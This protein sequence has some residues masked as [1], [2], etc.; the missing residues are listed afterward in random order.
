[1]EKEQEK[2][3]QSVGDSF[4]NEYIKTDCNK[5]PEKKEFKGGKDKKKEK[6]CN[7]SF[8]F[9][10][11]YTIL[12]IIEV[13]VFLLTYAIP[14]GNFAKMEYSTKNKVF[15]I[16]YPLDDIEIYENATQDT[17]DKY[18]IKIPLEN[19]VNN[20]IKKPISI[21]DTYQK[22]DNETTSFFFII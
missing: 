10:T 21:P 5:S 14:K 22:I 2:M 12:I 15:I 19:F 6:Y 16:K 13:F 11:A 4:I 1:M 9:P 3:M 18:N 20:Y 8:T 17:L 7:F